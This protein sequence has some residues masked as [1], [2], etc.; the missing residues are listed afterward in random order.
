MKFNGVGPKI[1][2][3]YTQIGFGKVHGI[4]VDTHCHRIPNRLK[5]VKTANPIATK[6]E[7]E[8]IFPKE[9]W[10]HVNYTLVGFGQNICAAVK[11]KCEQ[12]P[13]NKLCTSDDNRTKRKHK[14]KVRLVQS[15]K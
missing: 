4:S 2:N 12:C 15:N 13:I 14:A 7:L 8:K 6:A 3:L 9:E 11:P 10:E 1:A 5:W